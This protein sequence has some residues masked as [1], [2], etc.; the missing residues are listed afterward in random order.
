MN[1]NVVGVFKATSML[2]VLLIFCFVSTSYSVEPCT[3]FTKS[4]TS[5]EHRTIYHQAASFPGFR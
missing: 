4:L 2:T 3:G 5:A 1:R